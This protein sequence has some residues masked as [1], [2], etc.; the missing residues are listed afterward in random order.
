MAWLALLAPTT[1]GQQHCPQGRRQLQ[2]LSLKQAAYSLV[3]YRQASL[4]SWEECMALKLQCNAV[5]STSAPQPDAAVLAE[6]AA[7]L[8][9]NG[10]W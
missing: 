2:R 5:R 8:N 10:R 4:D 9:H 7:H 1:D 3:Q 6:P